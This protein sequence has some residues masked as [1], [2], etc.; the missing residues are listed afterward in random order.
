MPA[1]WAS[2][3]RLQP[4]L[5]AVVVKVV[6]AGQLR[7]I[8]VHMK[9]LHAYRALCL[10]GDCFLGD[11]SLCEGVD[12]GLGSRYCL[13]LLCHEQTIH[14]RVCVAQFIPLVDNYNYCL[15][16]YWLR[17]GKLIWGSLLWRRLRDGLGS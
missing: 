15:L 11:W 6:K 14:D 7:C 17:W 16:H 8:L 9:L 4:G 1:H 10:L 13:W 2:M 12:E 3:L 5:Y